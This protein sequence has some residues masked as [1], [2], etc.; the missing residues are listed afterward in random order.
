MKKKTP[1][2]QPKMISGGISDLPLAGWREY[3]DIFTDSLWLLGDRDNSG[4]HNGF[5]HGNFIPQ[6]PQQ[7]MRRYTKAGGIVLDGFLGSGTTM[8]EAKRM[9]RNSIGIELL[10][11]MATLARKA[12]KQEGALN[13]KVFGEVI[14]GDS[15]SAQ[16][17]QKVKQALAKNGSTEVD[18]MILHPPYHDIIAFSD[19]AEDLCNAPNVDEFVHRFG[20]VIDNLTELLRPRHYLA[21]VIGDKYADSQWI[22]LGFQLMHETLRRSNALVLKSIVVKN[23]INNRAKR[24]REN[25]W[26]VRALT[27]G[28]YIFRHEYILLFQKKK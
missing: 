16:T 19:R 8:I 1:S 4:K 11:N 24:H 17:R 13:G 25:L 22:P 9:G 14:T 15:R 23:M 5:Y 2:R 27:G 21:V 28:F 12:F 6:I 26:R 18:L 3:D 7:L 20:D 10:P